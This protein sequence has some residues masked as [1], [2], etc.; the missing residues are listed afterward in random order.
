MSKAKKG[1]TCAR[2]YKVRLLINLLGVP[3]L[4]D[5]KNELHNGHIKTGQG[6]S[7]PDK[8]FLSGSL[9]FYEDIL[10]SLHKAL[11]VVYNITGHHI[12]A[13]Q[14]PDFTKNYGLPE[15][16]FKEKSLNEVFAPKLAAEI[17][18]YIQKVFSTASPVRFKLQVNFPKGLCWFEISLS[19]LLDSNGRT[20]AV[21]GY[22]HDISS[23]YKQSD[24]QSEE[25]NIFRNLVES[26]PNAI[27]KTDIDKNISYVN[28]KF[29]EFAGGKSD[30]YLGKSFCDIH[31]FQ[32]QQK[33]KLDLVFKSVINSREPKEYEFVCSSEIQNAEEYIC[34]AVVSP[35]F[36][37]EEQT[38]FQIDISNITNRKKT[39]KELIF[40][41][42]FYKKLV[43]NMQEG[44][45]VLTHG[46][47]EF[48]NA[49]FLKITG[50]DS[51][52][53]LN[54]QF[55]KIIFEDDIPF[56]NDYL[57]DVLTEEEADQEIR[58][59]I[60]GQ[61]NQEVWVKCSSSL[62]D[63]NNGQAILLKLTDISLFKLKED[64]QKKKIKNLQLLSE[65]A[66]YFINYFPQLDI[67]N[68]LGREVLDYIG[69]GI[70][71]F[72]SY[73]SGNG[74][75]VEHIASS[76]DYD[77]IKVVLEKRTNENLWQDINPDYIKNLSI[78]KLVRFRDGHYEKTGKAF[79][80]E[81][82][83]MVEER[84]EL[85][86]IYLIGLSWDNITQ[87]SLFILLPQDAKI[88]C[89]KTLESIVEFGSIA[90]RRKEKIEVIS[91]KEEKYRR[92]FESQQDI[93]Y[94][95]DLNGIILDLG[96]SIEQTSG[97][98]SKEVIGHPA[99]DF[100]FEKEKQRDLIIKLIKD[101]SI[102]D[103]DIQII[104]KDESLIDISL[105]IIVI[106]DD[107]GKPI[108]YEGFLRD[109]SERKKSEKQLFESEERFKT[110]FYESPDSL[111]V[112]DYDGNILDVN[113]AACKLHQK[114]KEELI[115][116]NVIDLVPADIRENLKKDYDLWITGKIKR[117]RSF[118]L[119]SKGDSIPV[120]LHTSKVIYNGK[121]ALL[122]ICRD[123]TKIIETERILK[124][125]KEK[126]E[127]A[128]KLKSVFLANMSHEIRTPMNAIVGFSEILSDQQLSHEEREEFIKYIS[129]GSD[130][131]MNL[132]EDII[133]ITKIEA[134]QITVN[135]ST[136]SVTELMDELY[137][138]FL[139]VKNRGDRKHIE[140]RLSKPI[141][142]A[143]LNISTDPARV[144]QILS[145]L[146]GNSLKFTEKG[147]IEFGF[148][149]K[150]SNTIRFFVKDTGMGIE[151]DKLDSIFERFVQIENGAQHKGT[152]LGL[153]ISL[154]LAELL[155]GSLSVESEH[156]VGS[157]FHLDL[158]LSEEYTTEAI[159]ERKIHFI[160]TNWSTKKFL[161]A[162]DSAL[163]YSY[164]EALFMKTKVKLLWAKDGLEAVEVCRRNDDID[165]VLMDIKMPVMDGL[166]AITEIRKFRK[167]VPIIVQSA[168]A[169]LEDRERSISAG[170]NEHLT[171]PL[172]ADELFST[173]STYLSPK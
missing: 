129:Q 86:E 28:P 51:S 136:C 98:T 143:S 1:L 159:S 126:A 157:E 81:I 87:G 149:I 139:K 54:K 58:F 55:D 74:I 173:I 45:L 148:K 65:K 43:E 48:C 162:E 100:M 46:K 76:N 130:T 171:K 44:V 25:D 158:P 70:L 133:D 75:D 166:G 31:L 88:Q 34:V 71:I 108:G 67:Y 124:E 168:Y 105:N 118:A 132:I 36:L 172:N 41:S 73:K 99:F 95:V 13:W 135:Y 10:Q 131:L 147:V 141:V 11:I 8:M 82:I 90:L 35:V 137:A 110:L 59:R 6:V 116:M 38:G 146:L 113:P 26:W 127:Q 114:R 163:N 49:E 160:H 165:L 27:I 9:K 60:T 42:Q 4:D 112:E 77:D 93:Y 52:K 115:G 89:K 152:G 97:Y 21:T 125:A 15:S 16:N 120:E 111:F 123:I 142:D 66:K 91:K 150:N 117:K 5:H 119:T 56:V 169:M 83:E 167:E 128:D 40:S 61:N 57:K 78:D 164:L 20:S 24:T 22:F 23:T 37:I 53:L 103:Y 104:R 144:K 84:K 154:K 3:D 2:H 140:L 12:E 153:S 47:I 17:L 92:I 138:I 170:A 107:L 14:S 69:N 121:K 64:K 33:T 109:I 50:F 106:T 94:K 96:H 101:G 161:I 72:V 30:D 145:N 19:P 63:W 7:N 18:S 85:G 151:Q 68:V 80:S 79:P 134:G 39:E 62:V 29:I 122:F 156:T 32:T 102:K 155:G